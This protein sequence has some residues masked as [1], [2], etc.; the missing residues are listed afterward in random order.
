MNMTKF[1]IGIMEENKATTTIF[2]SGLWE[3]TL[4]ILIILKIY[5]FLIE[6]VI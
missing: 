6:L 5:K 2:M 4:K 1:K 3:I